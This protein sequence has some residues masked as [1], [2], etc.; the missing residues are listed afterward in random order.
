MN[1]YDIA[2]QYRE[3]VVLLQNLDMPSE[4]VLDTVEGMQG[5]LIDKLKAVLIV[6]MRL[7]AEAQVRAEHGK[8]MLDSAKAMAQRAESL[9]T[10][11]QATIQGCGLALPLKYPEF[12]VALQRNPPSCEV[13]DVMK[14]PVELKSCT[15]TFAVHP[16]QA[17]SFVQA[18][19]D[20]ADLH[21]AVAGEPTVEFK[22]DKKAVL[23]TLKRTGTDTLPGAHLNPPAFRLTIR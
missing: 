2:T 21:Q 5:D 8:R 11:A 14:L 7:E 15:V 17:S 20:S 23:D 3:D 12:T 10:Y 1:L 22:P 6:A 16:A 18:I 13:V 9:R 4:A 19:R